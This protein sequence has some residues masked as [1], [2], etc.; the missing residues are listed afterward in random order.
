MASRLNFEL[1]RLYRLG[2]VIKHLTAHLTPFKVSTQTG[3]YHLTLKGRLRK[4][5]L[6]EDELVV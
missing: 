3:E 2:L 4:V 1:K 6:K 5:L